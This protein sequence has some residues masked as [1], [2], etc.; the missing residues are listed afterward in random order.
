MVIVTR[1]TAVV[2]KLEACKVVDANPTPPEPILMVW[3]FTTIVVG[4]A[5]GPIL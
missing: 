1:S 2:A 3:P 4:L 5:E